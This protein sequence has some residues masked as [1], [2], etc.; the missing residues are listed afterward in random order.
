[1]GRMSDRAIDLLQ[2]FGDVVDIHYT[3]FLEVAFFLRVAADE[4]LAIAFV[5]RKVPMLTD[6]DIRFL[7][8]EIVGG[9]QDGL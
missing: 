3:Q 8:N 6:E 7:I 4:R 9:Y 1:M 2:D 5:K